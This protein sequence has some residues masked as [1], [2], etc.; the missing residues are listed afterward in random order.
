MTGCPSQVLLVF[1][2]L[3]P[4]P[5]LYLH[6]SLPL[7]FLP[8]ETKPFLFPSYPLHS[9][10]TTAL[11][12]ACIHSSVLGVF[13]AEF[14]MHNAIRL[15]QIN[16]SNKTTL[17]HSLYKK[18]TLTTFITESRTPTHA[19]GCGCMQQDRLVLMWFSVLIGV[20]QEAEWPQLGFRKSGPE[21]NTTD[22]RDRYSILYFCW[23]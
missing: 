7:I 10:R 12:L 4:S 8:W 11:L 6:A 23:Y 19:E 13:Y 9:D 2:T 15:A 20:Q 1:L 3:T 21:L 5:A 22:M 17:E 16:S 18:C 14:C